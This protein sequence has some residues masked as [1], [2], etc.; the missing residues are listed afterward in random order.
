MLTFLLFDG[1]PVAIMVCEKKDLKVQYLNSK[2]QKLVE[3][4]ADDLPCA[5]GEI[6]GKSID[7]FHSH[8][9]HQ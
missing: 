4:I 3:D 2:A 7:I 1:L 8:P 6:L 9:E 5:P